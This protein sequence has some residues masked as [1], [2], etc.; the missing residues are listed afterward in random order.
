MKDLI[1]IIKYNRA[2]SLYNKTLDGIKPINTPL[3][4]YYMFNSYDVF[5]IQNRQIIITVDE[6][7]RGLLFGGLDDDKIAYITS[8]RHNNQLRDIYVNNK[9]YTEYES[10]YYDKIK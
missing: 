4:T 2:V 8:V 6:Y 3:I 9:K 7:K 1:S 10:S 5:Y